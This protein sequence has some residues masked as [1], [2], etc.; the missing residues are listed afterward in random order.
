M[1]FDLNKKTYPGYSTIG[2]LR[3]WAA[4]RGRI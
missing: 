4:L 3:G 1:L 2:R